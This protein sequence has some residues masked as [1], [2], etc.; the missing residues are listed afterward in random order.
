MLGTEASSSERSHLS[1]AKRALLEK[2]KRGEPVRSVSSRVIPS[3]SISNWVPASFGQERLWFLDQLEPNTTAYLI[4]VSVRLSGELDIFAFQQSLDQ[5]IQRHES[6]RTSF[7]SVEGQPRQVIAPQ[8]NLELP[9]VDLRNLPAAVREAKASSLAAAEAQQPFQ[10]T[11]GPLLRATLLRLE[12]EEHI[13]LLTFHHIISDGWSIGVLLGEL[14]TAYAGFCIG[15]TPSLPELEIQYADFALWQRDWVQG[16][17]MEEQLEYWKHQLHDVPVLELPTDWPRP[18]IQTFRGARQPLMLSAEL[19]TALQNLSRQEGVTL[20]MT[21]LAAFQTLLYRYTAQTDLAVGMPVAGRNWGETYPL[22]GLFLNTL[23]LRTNLAG[24]P[25]FRELLHR[26]QKVATEAYAHQDLPFE[27][28]VQELQPARDLSH[29]PLFQVM[30]ILQNTPQPVFQVP[31]LMA[32]VVETQRTT[33]QFDLSLA[34]TE[35]TE[36]L[37]G[38]IEYNTDLFGA[39]TM[40]RLEEHFQ[41]LLQAITADADQPLSDLP[42][43]TPTE[44]QRILR[45]WNDTQ[46]AWG[47]W[48]SCP[49]HALIAAQADRTPEAIAA[50]FEN[51]SITYRELNQ[52]ANQLAHYLRR[53]GIGPDVCV[54][55]CADRSLELLIGLLA[56]LKA[57][58]AYVP[59][60]P[61]FPAQRLA[62]MLADAQVPV[63]LT[64]SHLLSRLPEHSAQVICL[65][66]AGEAWGQAP[67]TNPISRALPEHLAY[68]IYTSGSTGTPKGV[69]ITH[70]ALINFLLALRQQL[71]L[72]PQD[73]LLSVTTLSFDITGL[74]L[75]LPWL[76][77][78]C[79]VLVDRPA[80][81]DGLQLSAT[82]ASAQPTIMQATPATW[83]LLLEAGWRGQANLRIL[84]GGDALSPS[85]AEELK[86]R[87]ASL[88]NL[89]GPTETTIWSS[90]Q[91]ITPDTHTITLGRPIANTELYVLDAHR[92]PVPIGIPGELY[93]GGTGLARGYFHRPDLTADRFVPHPFNPQPGARLYRTGDRVRYRTDGSIEFLGRLDYQVKVRG[94]RIELG[95]VE[96]ILRQHPQVRDA[97]VLVQKD[98]A[99]EENVLVAYV[100]LKQTVTSASGELR[101]FV[102]DKLPP[103]MV[104]SVFITLEALPLTPNGKVD[105]RALPRPE[106]AQ[107]ILERDFVAP[108]V[109]AEEL[110][111]SLWCELLGLKQVGIHDNFFELGGHSLLATRLLSRIRDVFQIELPV[112]SLFEAPTVAGLAACL[113]SAQLTNQ[114][115]PILPLQPME[116]EGKRLLSFAQQRLWF[117]NLL[118]PN[119]AAYNIPGAIRVQGSLNISILEESL[120][121]MVG[122]H[123]SLRTTFNLIEDIPV[124]VVASPCSVNGVALSLVDLRDWPEAEREREAGR[125]I[126]EEIQRPFDLTT[127]PLLRTL[128]LRLSGAEHILLLVMHHIISDGWSLEIFVRELLAL[129]EAFS[130]D[131]PS[132]LPTLPIQ[133]ADF[134]AWQREWL[135]GDVLNSQLSYWKQQL[136]GNLPVLELPSDHAHPPLQT[137]RGARQSFTLSTSLTESVKTLSRQEKVTPFM[138]LLAAFQVL[139]HRYSGQ[140]DICV[141]SP[142]ANRNRSEIEGLIGFFV[143]TLVLRTN[144][145]GDP[146]FQELLRRVREM[147]LGAFAHQELP[148][149]KLVEE[150]QPQR[151]L[152][153]QPLFQVMFVFQGELAPVSQQALTGLEISLMEVESETAQFDLT[154]LMWATPHGLSGAFKYNTALF[155]AATMARMAEHFQALLQGIVSQPAQR[156]SAL[157]LLTAAEQ[158]QLAQWNATRVDYSTPRCLHQMIEAQV[159]R[160]PDA[161]AVAFGEEHLTYQELNRR[162]NQLARHLLQRG[163][164]LETRIGICVERS[165]EM[166]VG[167][168]GILKAGGAYLPLDPTYPSERLAFML[169]N[170][171]VLLLLTQTQ[172]AARLPAHTAQ[173]IYLDALVPQE[174]NDQPAA[175]NP[176]ITTL[177][178]SLAYV[179]Y[180]SGSTGKPKGA[181]NTHHGICNRLQW[182]QEAYQLTAA[183]RVMQKT[184]FSF[185]VSVWEFFWTLMTGACLVVAQPEGHKD[186]AYLTRLIS[187]EHVTTLHFVPSMLQLFVEEPGLENCRSLKRVI[188]SGEAL[189]YSLQERFFTRSQAE[190]HNL[191]GP[192]EAA[193]D[194]TFW[195]CQ[196]G[197]ER[198]SVPIGRPIANTQIYLL[199][200]NLQQVPPGVPGELHIGGMGL[201]RGY[202]NRPDLTADKFIPHPFSSEGERL[203]KTG[204]LARYLPSGAIEYLGRIDHQIKL[205]GFRIELGEIE[206]ALAA[207]P[208][209]RE[210]LVVAY[211]T[212]RAAGDKRLVAYLVPNQEPAPTAGELSGFLKA[213][214]PDYMVPSTFIML[215]TLPLLPNGKVDRRALPRPDGARPD[216][217]MTYVAPRSDLER[218]I[219]AIWQE[220]LHIDNVGIHDNFFERGGHSLLLAQVYN[221]LRETLKQ[222][223]PLLEM[224]KYPTIGSLAEHLSQDKNTTV[225]FAR[226]A[227][228]SAQLREGQ[229]RLRQQLAKGQT[230]RESQAPVR[231]QG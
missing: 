44:R 32:Q 48:G 55:L 184:P 180:T 27:R 132:P 13:L 123:E 73:T 99:A 93:I 151:D 4:P 121:E 47:S 146:S 214:L 134:T 84:C 209:L 68:L 43:L 175:Q 218:T 29:S 138:L 2:L 144:L 90:L 128:L 160:T 194:V 188:C 143:N 178:D 52:R 211:D 17:A 96:T 67:I 21:L 74:E 11:Q 100:V 58:G 89:Y 154:L 82:L 45:D 200:Q 77:G 181:M 50:R 230:R 34:L 61:Q 221:K 75:Y 83:R 97:I 171:Q 207:H 85:L 153:R 42:L 173:V 65:D 210:T 113:G 191:Y 71:D 219:A 76:V 64:H 40:A 8:I 102:Q 120:H 12:A 196:A 22:I 95:E 80:T 110:L 129:Y 66:T 169:A 226:G 112:R 158:A 139:L 227:D 157:P 164:G 166:V 15:Q 217:A 6:L 190:L 161:L 133:Y 162:A 60:D 125:L 41:V 179:I 192:T 142:I 54:A 136:G 106:V 25:S 168:L 23:V 156:L 114:S 203:Y 59:L 78:A 152:S 172:L 201:A 116:R 225:P 229:Q 212:E 118:E 62:F 199:D 159:E 30:L 135:T 170:A 202:V 101:H 35:T 213:T 147:T 81:G 38:Q 195:A 69:Q 51:Q 117:L 46:Q 28:L 94:F 87:S 220:M 107:P 149:E 19:R 127:G 141:G 104:P 208:A 115:R 24:N 167:L 124:P 31:G 91:K 36:G 3:R 130:Q 39:S 182:M 7:A 9:I 105:R 109:P 16:K 198:Q 126:K 33:S 131:R 174:V 86:D 70:R 57:D 204:D 108:R 189:P 72:T 148:F 111:A 140:T 53:L 155:E 223:L 231:T 98:P 150:L 183:D 56:I 163:A 222:D 1:A 137:Y 14:T 92:Q 187:D 122:R 20:F 176:S 185:D 79:V 5:V 18:A 193:V 206:A 165:L 26:V 197:D 228:R 10:L 119:S 224:F 63:L 145:S 215:E 186:A 216:L 103:Y 177:G 88:W 37:V 49:L 205:R